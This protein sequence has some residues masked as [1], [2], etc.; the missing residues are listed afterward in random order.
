MKALI[1]VADGVEDLEFFYPYYRLKEQGINVDVAGVHRGMVTGKHGYQIGTNAP[2]SAAQTEDYD[3][4]ILPGGKAP[5]ELRNHPAV[6]ET[7]KKML[8][9]GKIVAAICHAGQI[10]VSADVLHGRTA[11]CFKGIKDDII[12]AGANYLDQSVVVDGNLITSRQP[13]DLP[14]FCREIFNAISA[15]VK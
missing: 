9:D 4:L 10:L 15:S 11:T 8:D 1:F 14:D 3:I 13:D 7:V 2:L 5:E 12:A 6:T